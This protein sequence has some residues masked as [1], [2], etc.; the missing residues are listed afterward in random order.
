[1][2]QAQQY[3]AEGYRFVVDLDLEKFFDRVNHDPTDGQDR[4]TGQQEALAGADPGVSTSWSDGR[5][6]GS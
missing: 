5:R 3:I 4:R 1:V 6:S 2:E